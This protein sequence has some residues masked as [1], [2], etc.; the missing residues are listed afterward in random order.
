MQCTISS[1]V[2]MN[3]EVDFLIT[4]K[5]C[6]KTETIMQ[7]EIYNVSPTSPLL[8]QRQEPQNTLTEFKGEKQNGCNRPLISNGALNRSSERKLTSNGS[9]LKP[10]KRSKINSWGL[11]WKKKNCDDTGIDF[12]LKNILL[13]GNPNLS[14]VECDL[15]KKPYN[16]DLMYI[17]CETCK[18]K[19]V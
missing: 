6:N 7:N 13:K 19:H 1:T 4:C 10:K 2:Q 9:M 16:S 11:I 14:K 8:L 3:E 15:C 5:S 12:R 17:C 18:S